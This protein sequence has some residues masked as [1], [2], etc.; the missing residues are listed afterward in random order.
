MCRAPGMRVTRACDPRP[1]VYLHV[2]PPPK[3]P[4]GGT[5]KQ[6]AQLLERSWFAVPLLALVACGG[7]RPDPGQEPD[8]VVRDA[9]V[10]LR[11]DAAFT[12]SVD[13]PASLGP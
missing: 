8:F 7:V 3:V 9:A 10:V 5:A 11:T 4:T 6:M 1:H 13:F 12:R 2:P